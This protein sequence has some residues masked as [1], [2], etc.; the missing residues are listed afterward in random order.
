MLRKAKKDIDT[1]TGKANKVL[2]ELYRSLVKKR[3]LCNTANMSV[4]ILFFFPS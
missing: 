2:R 4:F 3:E 1:W